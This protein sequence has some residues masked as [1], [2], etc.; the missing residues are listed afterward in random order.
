M[1][2]NFVSQQ[3][4]TNAIY[5]ANSSPSDEISIT[6]AITIFGIGLCG[7]VFLFYQMNKHIR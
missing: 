5:L 7:I 6:S 2:A 4:T 1:G 3:M